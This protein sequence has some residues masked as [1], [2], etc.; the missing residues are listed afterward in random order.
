MALYNFNDFV[1]ESYLKGGRQP[2]YH[3]TRNLRKIL[4]TDMLKTSKPAYDK[5]NNDTISFS[6]SKFYT[7]YDNIRFML[8][9]D[10]MYEDD[11]R[12]E[13]IDEVGSALVTMRKDNNPKYFGYTKSNIASKITHHKLNIPPV[14]PIFDMEQEYEER[15]YKNLNNLGKYIIEIIFRDE[16]NVKEYKRDLD[17]YLKKYPHILITNPKG[18][19]IYE[20]EKK[21]SGIKD[22]VYDTLA[23][24]NVNAK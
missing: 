16:Y 5:H 24:E 17:A 19:V 21:K 20:P 10:L 14:K 12:P 4:E 3:G 18:Q 13:P 8:D 6:R 1:N 2:L 9:A 23:L 22:V 11:Y 15:L 7:D